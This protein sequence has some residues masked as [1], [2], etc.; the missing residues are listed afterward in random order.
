MG[1]L[2]AVT[3]LGRLGQDPELR[4]VGDSH[5]VEFSV[6]TTEK[7]K[8]KS[9]NDQE[10]TEWSKVVFWGG[11]AE[12]IAKYFKKGSQILVQ[13]KLKTETWEKEGQKHYTTKIQGERFTFVDKLEGGG[14]QQGAPSGGNDDFIEKDIPF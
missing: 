11:R 6:A 8:D 5:V 13:G 7:W 1:Y 12:T 3:I 4:A 2:N 14:G 10:F 9:G